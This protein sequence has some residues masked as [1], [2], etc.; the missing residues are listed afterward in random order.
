MLSKAEQASANLEQA[1]GLRAEGHS[2]RAIR[3]Q[4][5]ITPAQLGH[6]RKALKREKAARTRLVRTSPLATDRDLPVAQSVLPPGLRKRLVGAGFRTLGDLAD[7]VGDPQAAG[8]ETLDG[9]GPHKARLVT[10]LL[11]HYELLAGRSD[12]QAC[13]ERLFPEFGGD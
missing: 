5:A 9:I 10:T 12:L 11:E 2:Y 8:L 3:R 7:R 1:R 4:L 6:I 13:I